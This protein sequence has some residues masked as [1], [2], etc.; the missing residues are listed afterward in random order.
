MDQPAHL[1]VVAD[2]ENFQCSC[3]AAE[4]DADF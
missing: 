3:P 1:V 2:K 4:K